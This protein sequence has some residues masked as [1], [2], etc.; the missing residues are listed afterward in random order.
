VTQP[1]QIPVEDFIKRP[2]I[3]VNAN[4]FSPDGLKLAVLAPVN[5]RDNLVV[6]DLQKRTRSV[7]TN[8]DRNDV[9]SFFW[10]NNER[11][12]FN[13][14]DTRLASGEPRP[15]GSFAVNIDG[16]RPYEISD[17]KAAGGG[18]SRGFI[19]SVTPLRR[20]GTDSLEIIG[21]MRE[22]T[23]E[24]PDVYR[25]NTLNGRYELLSFET[26]GRTVGWLLDSKNVPRVATRI[27]E[28][29]WTYTTHY[30]S[31]ADGKWQEISRATGGFWQLSETIVPLAFD[32]DEKTLYVASNIGRD[33][34]AIYRYDPEQR[35]LLN[36]VFEHPLIDVT[37]GLLFES[38]TKK[39]IGVRYDAD[40]ETT[41]WFDERFA[42]L[43]A[44]LD[45]SFPGH[46]NIIFPRGGSDDA[47]GES[48][49]S[50]TSKSLIFSYSAKDPGTVY[51]F[52]HTQDRLESV[53]AS[54]PWLNPKLMPERK[55]IRYKARDGLEIPAWLTLPP[56][57]D[58][59]ALPL[60]INIHGGPNVRAYSANPWGYWNDALLLASRG[61]AVLEPEPR[62]STG[63]G[64]RHLDLGKRQWG[65]TMQDD[66]TD[67]ALHLVKEG[68]VDK[69]RM[70]LFGG[71]YGGYATL[72][73]L[74]REPD[75]FKCGVSFIA[76]TDLELMISQGESD[77][78]ARPSAGTERFYREFVVDLATQREQMIATSPA[79][80]ASKI[81]AAVMLAMGINDVRVPIRHGDRF[82]AAMK[83]AG[84]NLEYV[85]YGAEAHGFAKFENAVDFAKRYLEFFDK[86]I[87]EK[88]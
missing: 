86:H 52:D 61:Y 8:F 71:S 28:D 57:R 9:S 69:S 38:K 64:R 88:R 70:C 18:V 82:R 23:K 51:L 29:D 83:D 32:S 42:K 30:R 49:S 77:T 85:A 19:R 50:D 74:V 56:G 84:K 26:P 47:P 13:V 6:Y 12:Q 4:S 39:L 59:K 17:R 14:I 79:L 20:V 58:A 66:L 15:S 45:K 27:E 36:L 31:S 41:A 48:E 65:L 34:F 54:R 60:V 75:L 73:G 67:G 3:R 44:R 78:N 2:A 68:I 35:K 72:M 10:I 40:V 22:R 62:G 46:T 81:K 87:G 80:Q 33:K 25:F 7:V 76:V 63:F 55:F 21:L 11:I 5:G 24:F 43:Q 1:A 37:G 53:V 16:S